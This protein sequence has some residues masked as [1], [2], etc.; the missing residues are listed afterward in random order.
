MIVIAATDYDGGVEMMLFFLYKLVEIPFV[1]SVAFQLKKIFDGSRRMV[2]GDYSHPIDTKRMRGPFREH[3]DH[4]NNI[5]QG[6]SR[7]VDEQM[8]SE[9]FKTELITNVSHDIKTP[10]TSIINY[11]DLMEKEEID[12]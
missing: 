9:R 12:N 2:N 10:L 1:F 8:K 5:G 7:A 3:A 11:V 4:M 6:I